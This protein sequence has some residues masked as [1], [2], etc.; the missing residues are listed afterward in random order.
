MQVKYIR[1]RIGGF[2]A[3]RQPGLQFEV[4]VAAHQRIEQK[5]VDALG[6]RIDANPRVEIRRTAL[7]DHH[8]RVRI[9]LAGAGDGQQQE[10]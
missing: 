2:P 10:E 7:D 4:F 8:Q 6:L 3:F 9:G 1:L 5:V